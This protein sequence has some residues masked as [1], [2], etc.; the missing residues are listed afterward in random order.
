MKEDF[1]SGS[2]TPETYSVLKDLLQNAY[3]LKNYV[4]VGGSAIAMYLKHR[5]SED[6]DFFTYDAALFD[7]KALLEYT[8]QVSDAII[9]NDSEQGIDIRINK[10]KITFFNAGW[11]FLTPKKIDDFNVAPIDALA[12]MKV[13]ALFLRAKYRD[14]YDLYFITKVM[15][16][17]DIFISARS[18]IP[19]ITLK[20]FCMALV[21]V[22]DVLDESINHLC[23]VEKITKYQIRDFFQRRLTEE[24]IVPE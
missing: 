9:L 6:L 11:K 16:L 22:E 19:G 12:A 5:K 15:N 14:Y 17:Q 23:P 1:L 24:G 7:K 13:H 8:A 20:L 10:T 3:F 4:F 21:Y 2:L 18:I